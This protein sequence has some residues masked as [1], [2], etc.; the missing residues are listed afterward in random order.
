MKSRIFRGFFGSKKCLHSSH[1]H[2]RSLESEGDSSEIDLG[3]DWKDSMMRLIARLLLAM[4]CMFTYLLM[5][6]SAFFVSLKPVI[7]RTSH[8]LPMTTL[9]I[10]S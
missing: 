7:F 4:W 6:S 9:E 5:M 1:G 10:E 8:S 2:I 3:S